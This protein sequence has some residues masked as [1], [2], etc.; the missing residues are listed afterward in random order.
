M[1][2]SAAPGGLDLI[3]NPLLSRWRKRSLVL[4]RAVH[5]KT[6]QINLR[7]HKKTPQNFGGVLWTPVTAS[8][9]S[10]TTV[11]GGPQKKTQNSVLSSDQ[12]NLGVFWGGF[13]WTPLTASNFFGPL[14]PG[15]HKK[16]PQNSGGV[17]CGPLETKVRCSGGFFC[18]P[19][20]ILSTFVEG[21]RIKSVFYS[22]A[23][24]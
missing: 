22:S 18:G 4:Y 23:V 6:P 8:T 19:P 20:C 7:V 1:P 2:S 15:V 16:T 9:F 12:I 5:N 21:Y 3:E 13:L 24:G 17:F 11:S 14:F 10:R